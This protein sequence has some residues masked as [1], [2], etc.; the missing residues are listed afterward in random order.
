MKCTKCGTHNN[1][2]R[3]VCK[4]CGSELDN[5]E[6][7]KKS[8]TTRNICIGVGVALI[9]LIGFMLIPTSQSVREA[10]TV[11][12]QEAVY[13][14]VEH[15]DP[16]YEDKYKTVKH[17]DPV[18]EYTYITYKIEGYKELEEQTSEF[19]YILL[20]TEDMGEEITSG[21]YLSDE[22]WEQS[23]KYMSCGDWTN[24]DSI[25]YNGYN[26]EN[27]ILCAC[28]KQGVDT[29]I[30]EL[31]WEYNWGEPQYDWAETQIVR[32][33]VTH[34]LTRHIEITGYNTWTE[35]VLDGQEIT[36]YDSWSETVVDK[37]VTKE[38]TEYRDKEMNC[39]MYEK[40]GLV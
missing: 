18:S 34:T 22:Q 14:T 32:E 8:K 3:I 27:E 19:G 12:Y 7:E 11:E 29:L 16:V 5:S 28:E 17:S 4:A 24:P 21:E 35:Q 40:L 37:Y 33:K 15:S 2:E 25:N 9:L 30:C 31:E 10:Y 23:E 13:K 26:D 36:G 1:K 39:L 38:K 6:V 20:E